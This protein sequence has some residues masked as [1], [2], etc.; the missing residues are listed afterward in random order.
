MSVKY[1]FAERFKAPQGEGLYTGTQ[2]A[3]MRL[4]GCSVGK[5]ICTHCDTE[6]DKVY[7][8]LDGGLYT[9]EEMV[10]WAR[11]VEHVCFTG[12]EPLDRDLR[13]LLFAFWAD[14]CI[15]HI[16]TSGT[17]AP[18][19]LRKDTETDS[20]QVRAYEDTLDGQPQWV[21]A[22]QML[23]VTVS[24]KP[25]YKDQ[26]IQWADEL[27]V[28]VGGLGDGPGW[29]TVE[30]A[31]GWAEAGALVYIQPRNEVKVVNEENLRE[32]IRLLYIHPEL[33]LSAQLHKFVKTR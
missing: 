13:H 21:N 3:F 25:N 26:M 22:G 17:V 18:E 29:P 8:E 12:G 10:A 32:V 16:E 24:P 15:V 33:R 2:F 31:V 30:R 6:F 9:V 28:I 19:W 7:T 23:W 5:R 27:K 14:G 4:V 1:P 11:P 20:W